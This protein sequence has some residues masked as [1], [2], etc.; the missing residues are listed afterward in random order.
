[1]TAFLVI[2]I[3]SMALIAFIILGIAVGQP[4]ST[5][6]RN[7]PDRLDQHLGHR[8]RYVGPTWG[9][10]WDDGRSGRSGGDWSGDSGGGWSSYSG[11][12]SGD[13]GGGW[14][15]FDVGGSSSGAGSYGGSSGSDGGSSSSG[16]SY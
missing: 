13:S 6:R 3:I 12:W 10:S 11:G 5:D 7:D 8:R 15:G 14:S 16:R 4:G 2:L 1:M 9:N